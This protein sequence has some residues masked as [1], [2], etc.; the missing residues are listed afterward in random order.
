MYIK[1]NF[2]FLPKNLVGRIG[3]FGESGWCC[4]PGESGDSGDTGGSGDYSDS[5]ECGE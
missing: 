3:I 5:G 1:Q 4:L 2:K